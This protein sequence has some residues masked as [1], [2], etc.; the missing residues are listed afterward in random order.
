MSGSGTIVREASL[1]DAAIRWRSLAAPKTTPEPVE[2]L[3]AW[4]AGVS[5][6]I[7]RRAS[8]RSLLLR[9][10]ERA[11]ER[12]ERLRSVSDAALDE[13]LRGAREGVRL[14]RIAPGD[15]IA[16]W[17]L[18][19]EAADRTLGQRPYAVQVAGAMAIEDGSAVEMA[20]GEGKTLVTGLASVIGGWR[21]LGVHVVTTN[22]Y[23]AARDRDWMAPLLLRAGV[24]SAAIGQ[25]SEPRERRAAYAADVTY[26]TSKEAA[27]DMLRDRLALEGR[28]SLAQ[29]LLR[30]C[31]GRATGRGEAMLVTRGQVQA[32]VDEADSVLLDEASTP[33]IISAPSPGGA[34][35]AA[36][37]AAA[38]LAGRLEKGAAFTV[39]E[40]ERRV[41][42]TSRGRDLVAAARREE[43]TL[44]P[45]RWEECVSEALSARLFFHRGAHYVLEDGKAV[46]VDEATG[47][48]TPDRSW[49]HGF[50]QVI[51]AKEGLELTPVK[52][53]LA[54]VSF[55]RYFRLY[56]RLSGLSGTLRESAAELWS[57]YGLTTVTLPTNRPCRRREPADRLYAR[58]SARDAAAVGEIA[59]AAGS[60]RP[61]L[62]GVRRVSDAERLSELLSER[63]IEHEVLSAIRHAEE[64][65][66]ISKAGRA[67]SVT[68]A[69][70]MAGRGTDIR[71]DDGAREAGGLIV[72]A[73]E[74]Q[75]SRRLD[76]Q[77]FGRAGRQGD[78]G[79]AVAFG[80]LDDE[81]VYRFGGW[82]ART[83]LRRWGE[84]RLPRVA[85]AL[86]WAAQRRAARSAKRERGAVLRNDSWLDDALAFSSSSGT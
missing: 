2:G 77:L 61:V 18:L 84:R 19:V 21:G 49:R 23:L 59:R 74:R 63:G 73:L 1:G 44:S 56:E 78:P 68:V 76:R 14:Q 60:G 65:E 75:A 32:I 36:V 33:L 51:E 30:D 43:W 20:T 85:S 70:N 86:W 83:A 54:R 31:V 42:L 39:I 50:H 11:L 15:E 66:I 10:A 13:E 8:R 58:R 7:R 6:W 35:E 29:H 71:L 46:I 34:S 67:G 62:A 9:R 28:R 55:Q 72:I 80:S 22:D 26:L 47:R 5:G 69:T 12:A 38:T 27:A 57:I 48:L 17:A 24:S 79:E 53:T 40:R 52:E 37:R 45:R 64:A 25:E 82:A 16:L 41:T 81:V 3:D 4:R